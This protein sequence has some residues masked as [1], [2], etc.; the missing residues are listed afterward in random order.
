MFI[1][2]QLEIWPEDL[3]TF[4]ALESCMS[5]EIQ[6]C[7]LRDMLFWLTINSCKSQIYLTSAYQTKRKSYI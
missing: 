5:Y 6:T 7:P 1:E 4:N 3:P 2:G